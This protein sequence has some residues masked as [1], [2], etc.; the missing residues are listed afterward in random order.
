MKFTIT[1]SV[2]N[3]NMVYQVEIKDAHKPGHIQFDIYYNGIGDNVSF[4]GYFK[5]DELEAA[6]KRCI[7]AIKTITWTNYAKKLEGKIKNE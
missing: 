2:V 3:G 7:I 6:F 1:D 5:P 4:T